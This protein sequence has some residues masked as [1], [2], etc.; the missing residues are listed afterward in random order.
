MRNAGAISTTQRAYTLRLRGTNPDDQ[1]WRD[2]LWR[3]HEAVNRGAKVFGDWLLTFR[4]GLSHEL[5]TMK[6]PQRGET[7]DREPTRDEVRDRRITLALSWLS[8]ESENGAPEGGKYIVSNLKTVGTLEA[9]LR[10]RGVG[11]EEVKQWI[12]DCSD[13]LLANIRDDAVWVNRSAVFDSVCDD[14]L[15]RE[16]CWDLLGVVFGEDA[17]K[18]KVAYL[19]PIEASPDSN[20]ETL[21]EADSAKDLVQSAGKWL[22]R[23][24]GT[25]QGADFGRMARVYRAIAEWE[26]PKLTGTSGREVIAAMATHLDNDFSCGGDLRGIL[27]LLSGPGYKS[28][29][30]NILE[31]VDQQHTVQPESLESL[32]E[33]AR[34]DYEKCCAK[35]DL[36][37]RRIWSDRIL[38]DVARECGFSYLAEN[39]GAL[40]KEYS[41]ILDHAAR[42]VSAAHTWIKLA[43]KER[44]KF[45]DDA[46]R[47][48]LVPDAA[49]DLLDAFCDRR[50]DSSGA[51]ELYRIRR[52]AID[53]WKEVVTAWTRKSCKPRE[54]RVAAAR[55]LQSDVEKFGDIQLF[56]ALADDD[57]LCVWHKDGDSAKAPD[58]QPLID[59]VLA[60]EA[61]AKKRRF[62][63]PAYRHPDALLHPIFCDFG[64]SRWKIV[65]AVHKARKDLQ[66]AT[67]RADSK[68]SQMEKAELAAKKVTGNSEKAAKVQEKLMKAQ[69]DLAEAKASLAWLSNTHAL[70]MTLWTGNSMK[71]DLALCWQSKRLARDLALDRNGLNDEVLEVPRADRLGRAAV[72]VSENDAVEIAD[73]FDQAD[74]NGRLQAPRAQLEAIAAIRDNPCLSTEERER[75]V[76][77]MKDRIR[78]LVTFSAEFQPWGPWCELAEGLDL[79]SDPQY[80]PHVV[81]NKNRKGQA[82]LVLSRLPGIRVL[83]V[84]LGHRHAAACTV[85]EAVSTE[86]VK[87]ACKAAGRTPPEKESFYL[88]LKDGNRTIIYRRVGADTL[89]DGKPHPTP[90]ARLDRQFPIRLQGEEGD[91]RKAGRGE[92][93]AVERFEEAIGRTLFPDRSLSI[94]DL[95]RE[96]VRTARLAIKR[97]GDY[98]GIAF[99]LTAKKK[100][101]PG[102]KEESLSDEGRKALLLDTVDKWHSLFTGKGWS[103]G[104]AKELWEKHIEN[105]PGYQPPEAIEK[106]VSRAEY[107][108]K[109]DINRDRLRV[110]AEALANNSTLCMK[111]HVAWATRWREEDTSWRMHLRWLR[112]WILPRGKKGTDPAI[113]HVGGLSLDRIAT[114]KSL[115]QVQKAFF[116]RPEPDDLRKNIP[117]KGQD[118]LR[119][120]G[121]GLLDTM[122]RMRENRVKQ[123]ASRIAEAALGIGRM[124]RPKGGNDP[125]RPQSRVDAPCHAVVIENLTHYR[126]GETRTRREN[127][128]LMDW[129]SAKVKKYLSESCQLN[130]L[131]LREVQASYTSRQDSRTGAPGI[132]CNDISVADF[133]K[134]W[135]RKDCKKAKEKTGNGKGD[136]RERF[137]VDLDRQWNEEELTWSDADGVWTTDENKQKW[138][139]KKNLRKN[140]KAPRTPK[141][142]RIPVNGGDLF[143]STDLKSPAAKGLQADLNAAAN[144][145][146]RA[147]N[148]PDWPGKWW[149]IPA[150]LDKDG[151]RVPKKEQCGGSTCLECWKVGSTTT[152]HATNGK[153]LALGDDESVNRAEEEKG[154]AETAKKEAQKVLKA[155]KKGKAGLSEKEA[156]DRFEEKQKAL[157]T[158][159]Q[160]LSEAKKAA[161]QKSTINLWRD[162][163]GKNVGDGNWREWAAYWN[164]V[165]SR[166]ADVLRNQAGL[167]TTRDG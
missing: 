66:K 135:W 83:S 12:R 147:L 159:K 85:W 111:L 51:L 157:E 140:G 4:G 23:R 36:K 120:F 57:M 118:D 17:R 86:Q 100:M 47:M 67:K 89:P 114:I 54:D 37:G 78:W 141:P 31:Q 80:W 28:G 143:V 145:G 42:K 8:V 110:V 102:G 103:D 53:G 19:T 27:S 15:T 112:D 74:W 142:L 13:S 87:Q 65:F 46:T 98:A 91:V 119:G 146:L 128:Q 34:I 52:R 123:L 104:K 108:K 81:E 158:A 116:M 14:S 72:G 97:H 107:N 121:H 136:A 76:S 150:D 152:G 11:A 95:M 93:E 163:S 73:L 94:V 44:R 62:K 126:P 132:R 21:K 96:T 7:S 39:E 144:I 115:Y 149:Y 148:D 60:T 1:S 160:E 101:L 5:A 153:P 48:E 166:V 64:N 138:T 124:K 9:I 106:E 156:Q 61:E 70:S 151:W 139:L 75:R 99:N 162:P 134:P 165:N 58:P 56:D 50:T 59:Y 32:K 161:K 125:K 68:K 40:H 45:E 26:S 82:R 77:R 90:W 2:A 41:V 30:R 155:A 16:E 20:D 137:L 84:D 71:S 29:T 131:H 127:R 105:L 164:H 10:K 122:E 6:V 35:K 167:E 38:A 113:R 25:G 43:E 154:R 130:G 63:V 33:K 49:K 22:S 129:S 55:E 3:T 133:L 88:H 18:A 92:V 24:M 117:A 109:R 69:A 79:K